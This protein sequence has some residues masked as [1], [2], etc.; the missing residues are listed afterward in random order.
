MNLLKKSP[1]SDGECDGHT[2]RDRLGDSA[3]EYGI[4]V[5]QMDFPSERPSV[6]LVPVAFLAMVQNDSTARASRY[7]PG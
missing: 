4:N 2:S 6:A 7:G 3:D 1:V 5:P